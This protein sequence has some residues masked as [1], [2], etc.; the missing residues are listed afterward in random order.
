MTALQWIL[1]VAGGWLVLAV[2][3]GLVVGRVIRNRDRQVPN[4]TA[5]IREIRSRITSDEDGHV[6]DEVLDEL[7]ITI[8]HDERTP[9]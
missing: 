4:L 6:V 8:Q 1:V 2:V 5:A 3:V 7:N 9:S